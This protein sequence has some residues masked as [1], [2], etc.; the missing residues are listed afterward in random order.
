MTTQNKTKLTQILQDRTKDDIHTSLSKFPPPNSFKDMDKATTRIIKAIN[1]DENITVVGDYDVDG[2][3]STVI[4]VE[5]FEQIGKKIE[6]I[7]PN[8]FKHGYGLSPK[9]VQDIHSGLVITVDNGITA[10]ES[11]TILKN[12][13]IDLIITDHH[14]ASSV[15]PECFAII[16]PRQE[17][18]SFPCE[19]ICGAT[20]AWYLCASVNKSLNTDIVMSDF[21]DIV[22]VATIA[23]VM[24][25]LDINQTIVR[26]GLKRLPQ[27]QRA[28]M[29]LFIDKIG[30][31]TIDEVDIG[32][33]IAPLINSAGRVADASIAVKLMLSKSSTEAKR[34]F[35]N[36]V[37]LNDQRK[38]I[39]SDTYKSCLAQV[40]ETQGVIVVA[41]QDYHEG[42]LG[43]VA[44]RLSENFD[45]PAFVFNI[46]GD[47]AKASARASGDVDLYALIDT[48][49]SETIGFGGHKSAAGVEVAVENLDRFTKI[50]NDSIDDLP[51]PNLPTNSKYVMRLS[52]DD[53]DK[54]LYDTID[55]HKPYGHENELPVFL[56][57]EQTA[58]HHRYMGKNDEHQKLTLDMD[59]SLLLFHND[60]KIEM[61]KTISFLA[62]V[63]KNS[64]RGDIS[65]DLI[66][67]RF[68]DDI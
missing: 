38:K 18:C 53:I 45:R 10:Y 27:S 1:N 68:Y 33:G 29:K 23:D 63:S 62:T 44:A 28:A 32:F 49:K 7:V 64:F 15:L 48:A 46:K 3:V 54:E 42:V 26:Y 56:F 12:K 11:A 59:V 19:H 47:R 65:Y 60:T 52:I 37:A 17:Q 55:S 58:L 34:L 31:Q 8:R 2:V 13:S 21:L 25:M 50:L 4:M 6:W 22:A 61:S 36:L 57:Q 14:T 67:K 51:K 30:K 35:D 43:I 40:K 16:N 41:S 9:I 66:L 5:F 39:Q 24:P 20:V